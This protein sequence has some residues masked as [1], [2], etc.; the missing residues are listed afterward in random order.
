M[1]EIR[2]LKLKELF[3]NS[4]VAAIADYPT[5]NRISRF[6]S[7]SLDH[8]GVVFNTFFQSA[9]YV[10]RE[11]FTS[12]ILSLMDAMQVSDRIST[13]LHFGNPYLLE[14]VPHIPR[15]LVGTVS[16]A[17]VDAALEVLAGEREAKGVL[18]YDV[19]IK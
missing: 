15:V 16:S 13:I 6:L 7:E 14:E 2:E 5:P 10:G 3:P 8:D 19:K 1:K 4:T 17:G 11:C 9:C 18:T 12:R